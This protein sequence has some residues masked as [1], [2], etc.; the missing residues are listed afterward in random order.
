M[1]ID[2]FLGNEIFMLLIGEFLTEE[3]PSDINFLLL[4]AKMAVTPF[5]GGLLFFSLFSP[6]QVT[7]M[8]KPLGKYAWNTDYC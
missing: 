3:E 1:F 7:V 6:F 8:P 4:N 2:R 5:S